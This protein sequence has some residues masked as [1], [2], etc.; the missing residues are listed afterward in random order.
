MRHLT[1]SVADKPMDA[2]VF[3]GAVALYTLSAESPMQSN[4]R[5]VLGSP[6]CSHKTARRSAVFAGLTVVTNRQTDRQTDTTP[7]DSFE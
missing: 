6:E 3:V 7:S 5:G 1:T 4:P 2:D